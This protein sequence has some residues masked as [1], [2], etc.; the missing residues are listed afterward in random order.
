MEFILNVAPVLATD[1][2]FMD[3]ILGLIEVPELAED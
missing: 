3:I 1:V 2:R